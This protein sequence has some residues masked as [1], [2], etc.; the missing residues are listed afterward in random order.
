L[1]QERIVLG[2]T[3]NPIHHGHLICARAVA[4]AVGAKTLVV[5]PAGRPGHKAGNE[6]IAPAGDRLEMCRLA[7]GGRD[8]FE[9]DDREVRQER[10][11]FTIDTARQLRSEGWKAV[12]WIIGADMLNS[13][14]MWHEPEKLLEEVRFIIMARPGWSFEWEKLP[15]AYQKLKESVVEVP[16]IDIS[17]TEIRRRVKAGLAIDFL[18][19]PEVCGY[20]RDRGLYR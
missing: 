5:I 20:I 18:C 15:G 7:I 13:L 1:I 4:E 14:P 19:P 2:G 11:S 3:F 8:G 9:L 12:H 17:A 16:Q 10:P 6:E